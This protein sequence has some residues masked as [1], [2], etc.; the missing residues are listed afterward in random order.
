MEECEG[1]ILCTVTLSD[2]PVVLCIIVHLETLEGHSQRGNPNH[3][4]VFNCMTYAYLP[5]RNADLLCSGGKLL[6]VRL[7][8]ENSIGKQHSVY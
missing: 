7:R 5:S 1:E 3:C 2:W 6:E 8:L 4:M